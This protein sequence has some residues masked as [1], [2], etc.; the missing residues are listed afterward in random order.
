MARVEAEIEPISAREWKS[1]ALRP[2]FSALS[3]GK[4]AGRGIAMPSWQEGLAAYLG[5]SGPFG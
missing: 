3:N 4:L 5:V 2:R 1:V